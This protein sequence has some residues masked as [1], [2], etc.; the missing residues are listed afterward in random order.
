MSDVIERMRAANPEPHCLPPTIEAVWRRLDADDGLTRRVRRTSSPAP[1]VLSTWHRRLDRVVVA[2]LV[3]ATVAIAFAA[4]ALL[5]HRHATT[6]A[7]ATPQP[8]QLGH[9]G[10]PSS[11]SS[12]LAEL[13][14]QSGELLGRAPALRARIRELRGLPIVINVWASWCEPCRKQSRLVA[15]A[16]DRYQRRV[17]FLGADIADTNAAARSFLAHHPS[18]Y[19]SYQATSTQLRCLVPRG[20]AGIPTTI[21][22]DTTGQVISIHLGAYQSAA[23]IDREIEHAAKRHVLNAAGTGRRHQ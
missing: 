7:P 22:I 19:P 16:S 8:S 15:G 1:T 18:G 17:A 5:G 6:T 20:L 3:L 2:L 21:F 10:G 4:L 23:P 13:H 12:R 9:R 14:A 11:D